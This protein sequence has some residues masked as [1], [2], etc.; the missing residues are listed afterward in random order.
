MILSGLVLDDRQIARMTR[1]PRPANDVPVTPVATDPR[2]YIRA[3]FND[4]GRADVVVTHGAMR[5]EM[6]FHDFTRPIPIDPTDKQIMTMVIAQLLTS[7]VSK[8]RI[9]SIA[10]RL[11]VYALTKHVRYSMESDAALVD[12]GGLPIVAELPAKRSQLAG[13]TALQLTP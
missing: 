8:G 10:G 11:A 6:A 1:P 13:I 12:F 5:I 3:S 2:I 9:R 4:K 7:G